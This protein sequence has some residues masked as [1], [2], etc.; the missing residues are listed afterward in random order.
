MSWSV[1]QSSCQLSS[2]VSIHMCSI[3]QYHRYPNG[4]NRCRARVRGEQQLPGKTRHIPRHRSVGRSSGA[5]PHDP[6]SSAIRGIATSDHRSRNRHA[7]TVSIYSENSTKYRWLHRQLPSLR[8]C[9]WSPH[10]RRVWACMLSDHKA[11]DP[12]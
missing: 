5:L 3:V 4:P 2:R 7:G 6:C 8:P 9:T 10:P 12:R 11:W 1:C